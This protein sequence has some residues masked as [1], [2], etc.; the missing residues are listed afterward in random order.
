MAET[1]EGNDKC[2]SQSADRRVTA[3]SEAGSDAALHAERNRLVREYVV[4]QLPEDY[5][6]SIRYVDE[7][8]SDPVYGRVFRGGA[9]FKNDPY[10]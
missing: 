2:Y 1:S 8:G 10:K 7:I 3:W 9:A 4:R 5:G 6:L